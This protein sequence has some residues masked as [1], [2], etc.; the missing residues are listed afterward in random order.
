MYGGLIPSDAEKSRH[1]A[2]NRTLPAAQY[3]M[4]INNNRVMKIKI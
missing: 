1:P 2:A 4:T 3:A